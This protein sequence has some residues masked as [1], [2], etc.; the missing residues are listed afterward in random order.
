MAKG[1]GR[2][3]APSSIIGSQHYHLSV[4]YL[5]TRQ[6]GKSF[7]RPSA[8]ELRAGLAL[9]H[10]R[11]GGRSPDERPPDPVPALPGTQTDDE[12]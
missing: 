3:A 7:R 9:G 5:R 4:P 6:G 11:P 2:S 1:S 10:P 8:K 12:F